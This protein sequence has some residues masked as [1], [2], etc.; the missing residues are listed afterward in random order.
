MAAALSVLG[1]ILVLLF[2]AGFVSHLRDEARQERA[3]RE[4]DE[5]EWRE[6]AGS[7]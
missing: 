7:R 2:L 6:A 3:Q 4:R 5:Q 1:V